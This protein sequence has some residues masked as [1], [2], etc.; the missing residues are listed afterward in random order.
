MMYWSS[1]VPAGP[2]ARRLIAFF[3]LVAAL[4]C[5][6][7]TP[8]VVRAE[9]VRLGMSAAFSGPSRGLGIE[10]YRGS[11]AYFRMLNDQGGLFGRPVEIA[12]CDDRYE[13]EPAIRNTIRFIQN[14]SILALFNYV[15]TP[16]T[17]RVL[18]LLKRYAGKHACLLF[19]FTGAQPLREPPYGRWVFNLRA[20]YFQ[21]TE[22]LVD[23]MV[24]LGRERI[25][26]FY[27]A[28][29]YGRSGWA[30][31]RKALAEH[32]LSLASEATYRRGAKFSD[33]ML[34]QVD[35]IKAANPEAV[36]AVGSY[37]ACAAFI[38]DARDAGLDAPIANLSFVGSENLLSLLQK[39]RTRTG[40]DYAAR[41]L[42]TQ[43]V[44][45]YQNLQLPAVRQYRKLMQTYAPAPPPEAAQPG[46]EPL[47]FSFLSFEGFLNAK[48]LAAV[49]RRFGRVPGREEIQAAMESVGGLDLGLDA[50]VRFGPER[51]QGLDRVYF[52]TVKEGR[53]APVQDWSR[54]RP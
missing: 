6:L 34:R 20:S 27:Q 45:S 46:Y 22:A 30:G 2:R 32:A 10:L 21:E 17:T 54:W 16:T 12:A 47:G 15:G 29:A 41:L 1:H 50:P 25:S 49:V 40:R 42:N 4:L 7:P 53:F 35:I 14:D 43:V 44:P 3:T 36:I 19:P 48:A 51:H 26:V 5:M 8:G 39:L 24:S 33:S 9:P 38:R 37:E 52:T 28:D 23:R 31:V 13:P 18:P 11:M